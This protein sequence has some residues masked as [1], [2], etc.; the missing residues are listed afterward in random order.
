MLMSGAERQRKWR[1]SHPEHYRETR[2]KYVLSHKAAQRLGGVFA[3]PIV[4]L[5]FSVSWLLI[6][7]DNLV[8]IKKGRLRKA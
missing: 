1:L 8:K 7:A 5:M 3:L 4:C 2:E 6:C